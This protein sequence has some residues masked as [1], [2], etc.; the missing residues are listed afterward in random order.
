MVRPSI[1]HHNKSAYVKTRTICDAVRSIED[2]LDYTKRYKIQGRLISADLKKA[3]DSV[4]RNFLF[5]ALSAFHFGPQFTQWIHTFYNNI[6]SCV[7]NNGFLTAPFEVQ[8]GVR[9]GDPLSS[10]LFIVTLEILAISIRSN[11]SIQGIMVDGQ[12][13]KL[14]IFAD[15]LT[16]F[17]LNDESLSRLLDLLDN[18]GNCSGLKVN[19]VKSEILLLGNCT[20][21]LL[22]HDLFK[23]LKIKSSVKILGIHF[24]YDYCAKLKLNF[25]GLIKSIKEKIK[26]IEM[27]RSY[28]HR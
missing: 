10:S 28:H 16:A 7:M 20:S 26:N 1:I 27:E 2:I 15:D 9:Q 22:N 17:L 6:S 8:R 19:D 18:F 4:S 13:I 24:T 14:G 21:S 12:E 23:N 11:K 5:R 3:F 25:E